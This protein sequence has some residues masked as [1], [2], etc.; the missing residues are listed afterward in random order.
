MSLR[1]LLSLCLLVC[2]CTGWA[3]AQERPDL[4]SP[5]TPPPDNLDWKPKGLEVEPYRF[6]LTKDWFGARTSL[7]EFGIG[8]GARLLWETSEVYRGGFQKRWTYRW[9]ADLG[10][11]WELGPSLGLTGG[12]FYAEGYWRDGS[13]SNDDLGGVQ[14]PSNFEGPNEVELREL[15]YQQR[16]W[17]ELL[18]IKVG[19]VDGGK[20]FQRL[21]YGMEFLNFTGTRSPSALDPSAYPLQGE[22]VELFIKPEQELQI[23]IGMQDRSDS[24]LLAPGWDGDAW[25]FNIEGKLDWWDEARRGRIYMG[26][27]RHTGGFLDGDGATRTQNWGWYVG[28]EKDIYRVETGDGGARSISLLTNFTYGDRW[29]SSPSKHWMFGLRFQGLI[30]TRT[31]D[32]IGILASYAQRNRKEGWPQDKGEFLVETYYRID[33]GGFLFIQPDLQYFHHP[34][35]S[36]ARAESWVAALRAT[37]VF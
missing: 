19:R 5:Y 2:L 26:Y 12:K 34:G 23:G 33:I 6:G 15:Y 31:T 24:P 25:L 8:V 29:V 20:E 37:L 3:T 32:S 21:E 35:G 7:E 28:G 27:F 22:G 9:F 17:G 14:I 1:R 16:L 10:L 4:E 30:P 18:R 11:V 13:L 36:S